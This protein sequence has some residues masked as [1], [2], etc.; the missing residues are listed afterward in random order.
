MPT[1][2]SEAAAGSKS[3]S[4]PYAVGK[5]K[6]PKEHQFKPGNKRGGRKAGSRN[7]TDFDKLHDELVTI[8]EDRL[9]RPI[10]KRWREVIN[11]QLL[12]KAAKGDL[13]AIR[14]VKEYELKQAA[15]ARSFGPPPPT[16]A[17]IVQGQAEE[18]E[19]R[20]GATSAIPVRSNTASWVMRPERRTTNC[21]ARTMVPRSLA[22][23]RLAN[24]PAAVPVSETVQKL[25][26]MAPSSIRQIAMVLGWP[27][28]FSLSRFTTSGQLT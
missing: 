7:R 13:A 19:K 12:Q 28:K 10:R 9:G 4:K 3:A 23:L 15:L 6:P 2:H 18:A 1:D 17:E 22:A 16:P 8:G 14:I 20:M 21:R 11:R 24:S 26:L 25:L 27:A 5:G